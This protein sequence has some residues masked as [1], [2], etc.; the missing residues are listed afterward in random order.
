MFEINVMDE[1]AAGDGTGDDQPA[2][3]QAIDKAMKAGTRVMSWPAARVLLPAGTY[4][5]KSPIVLP[6]G[7]IGT[8]H[9]GG[10][11]HLI[12]HPGATVL[13]A[14]ATA[15]PER[16]GLIE[17][18]IGPPEGP[19]SEGVLNEAKL[20]CWL[21]DRV[22][23]LGRLL[24]DDYKLRG[25]QLNP[26]IGPTPQGQDDTIPTDTA[27][28]VE[29]LIG[30]LRLWREKSTKFLRHRNGLVNQRIEGVRLY[31]PEQ[32]NAYLISR[33][34]PLPVAPPDALVHLRWYLSSLSPAGST[35]LGLTGVQPAV[36]DLHR[37]FSGGETYDNYSVGNFSE[38]S[39]LQL[40]LLDIYGDTNDSH[41][42]AAFRFDGV[43]YRSSFRNINIDASPRAPL[44]SRRLPLFPG[45]SAS[46]L[47]DSKA[48]ERANERMRHVDYDTI[49]FLFEHRTPSG[50]AGADTTGFQYGEIQDVVVANL[51]GG[52]NCFLRGRVHSSTIRSVFMNR[53]L[54]GPSLHMIRSFDTKLE[55]VHSEGTNAHPEVLLD[56]CIGMRFE[57]FGLG[58]S[59][60][61][62]KAVYDTRGKAAREA[63]V[64]LS[65]SM[66]LRDTHDCDFV[67][68]YLP[69]D[70]YSVLAA[71]SV[72]RWRRLSRNAPTDWP[73]PDVIRASEE[74]PP[75]LIRIERG[76][77]R[78]RF[79]RLALGM[80]QEMLTAV[81]DGY[82]CGGGFLAREVFAEVIRN[83]IVVGDLEAPPT[84][85]S[86]WNEVRGTVHI[87]PALRTAASVV[88]L[89]DN[90][91]GPD[92]VP[93]VLSDRGEP[94]RFGDTAGTWSAV[95]ARG[96]WQPVRLM[97]VEVWLTSTAPVGG[98]PWSHEWFSAVSLAPAA[99]VHV[100]STSK[101]PYRCAGLIAAFS[102]PLPVS[103]Q[104]DLS[105][106]A[107]AFGPVTALAS[108]T[109]SCPSV[110]GEWG[111]SQAVTLQALTSL[112]TGLDFV[113]EVTAQA[114]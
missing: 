91:V 59:L 23:Q 48:R 21:Q 88:A 9:S 40:A 17:W 79:S 25:D 93:F 38:A 15:F 41:H 114:L 84:D 49:V 47:T 22:D 106:P 12:G 52:H 20:L 103:L 1:G 111:P 24:P 92:S 83:E 46:S 58:E 27:G 99:T 32:R 97:R 3:E 98:V 82:A 13:T 90:G 19:G 44:K 76:C 108:L 36:D 69:E 4:M 110:S 95:P 35:A 8:N 18:Q 89:G 2:I 45:W 68:R 30:V 64:R 105:N 60:P 71:E 29:L 96:P 62:K 112:G 31:P 26:S 55:L 33:R 39:R 101:L 5:L 70:Q 50:G 10:N 78:N 37:F 81:Q 42:L 56:G 87:A 86:G 102:S 104:L 73:P 61:I 6:G 53:A 14:H 74:F 100:T 11:V 16:R 66:V 107:M 67:G 28:V 77:R 80:G 72:T 57:G 7:R 43:L 94:A 75:S 63:G 54:F 51:A 113:F 109:V 65:A 85:G 34:W